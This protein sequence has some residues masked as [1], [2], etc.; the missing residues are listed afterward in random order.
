MHPEALGRSTSGRR[1]PTIYLFSTLREQ[2]RIV[3]SQP[4]SGSK[5]S[6]VCSGQSQVLRC[7]W[8]IPGLLSYLPTT[9]LTGRV[10]HRFNRRRSCCQGSIGTPW[11]LITAKPRLTGIALHR[12][13]GVCWPSRLQARDCR[14]SAADCAHVQ[15]VCCSVGYHHVLQPH[16]EGLKLCRCL[17]ALDPTGS[18]TTRLGSQVGNLRYMVDLCVI[19]ASSRRIFF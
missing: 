18:T 16:S 19:N 15:H 2:H 7:G 9:L 12:G 3:T 14:S 11:S 5:T 6:K 4:S 10:F 13:R 1:P 8:K 17:R